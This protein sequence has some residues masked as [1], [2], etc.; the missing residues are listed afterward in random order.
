MATTGFCGY[1]TSGGI[2]LNF[3]GAN[4]ITGS[5]FSTGYDTFK[6]IFEELE[7]KHDIKF[8]SEW[9]MN[10]LIR[11]ILDRNQSKYMQNSVGEWIFKARLKHALNTYNNRSYPSSK[12]WDMYI[13]R[14]IDGDI[15]ISFDDM[16]NI[17]ENRT[18]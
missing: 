13:S 3:S 6:T 4:I 10:E 1:S 2:L 11:V 5:Y 16:K 9:K 12:A 18:A 7:E 17:Y 14:I 15:F 8:P